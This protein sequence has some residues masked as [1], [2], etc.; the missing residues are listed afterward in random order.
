MH[1]GFIY[2]GFFSGIMGF[3]VTC[4]K[5]VMWFTFSDVIILALSS[6]ELFHTYIYSFLTLYYQVTEN[7]CTI[8]H[9]DTLTVYLL[10]C[11]L[12]LY[13]GTTKFIFRRSYRP[14]TFVDES[15]I[16]LRQHL[17]HMLR[18]NCWN[19]SCITSQCRIIAIDCKHDGD[20]SSH[21]FI[22]IVKTG[23]ALSLDCCLGLK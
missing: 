14:Q 4:Y 20:I 18:S 10:S 12:F 6:L 19:Q 5:Y 8:S 16:P 13:I 2:F 15:Q 11:P 17:H 22:Q 7:L 1:R 3:D 23:K 9:S 21:Y